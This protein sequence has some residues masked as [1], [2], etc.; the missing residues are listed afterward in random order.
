MQSNKQ[1]TH[2]AAA[3]ALYNLDDYERMDVGVNVCGQRGVL[4]QYIKQQQSLV[5]QKDAEIIALHSKLAGE[6]LRADKG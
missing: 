4:E 6:T 2:E 5:A 3:E 1:I